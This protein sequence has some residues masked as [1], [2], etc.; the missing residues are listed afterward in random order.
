[1]IIDDYGDYCNY[2]DDYDGDNEKERNIIVRG[3]IRINWQIT[4]KRKEELY[5]LSFKYIRLC[6]EL[7]SG[8]QEE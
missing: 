1:M 6:A 5:V 3:R 2:D 7:F 4:K 8:M